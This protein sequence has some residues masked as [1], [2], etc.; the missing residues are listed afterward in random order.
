MLMCVCV[1]MYIPIFKVIP[2]SI[3]HNID[4]N[5]IYLFFIFVYLY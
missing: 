3:I 2:T 1:Q 4:G 5:I